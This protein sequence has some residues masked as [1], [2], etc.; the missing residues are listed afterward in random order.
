MKS[1]D[2]WIKS[3]TFKKKLILSFSLILGLSFALGAALLRTVFVLKSRSEDYERLRASYDVLT[4]CRQTFN[5][6]RRAADGVLIGVSGDRQ[7]YDVYAYEM[8][9][10]L[11]QFQML[12]GTMME[13]ENERNLEIVLKTFSARMKPVLDLAE[14]GR[15]SE[16][17]AL[18]DQTVL[19]I[20][21]GIARRIDMISS[22]SKQQADQAWGEAKLLAGKTLVSSG[23]LFLSILLAGA[24]L[25]VGLYRSIAHPLAQ[26]TKGT[27][28][29]S[30][31]L[32]DLKMNIT[33][34][35][36]IAS[37]ASAFET[38]TASLY[39]LQVRLTQMDRMSAMGTLAGGVAHEINNP[40]TGVLGQAQFL[41][42]KLSAT[43][44]LRSNVEKIERGA[45]RCRKI[46]RHLLDFSRPSDYLFQAFDVKPVIQQ[47]LGLCETE[48]ALKSI[49][50]RF[51]SAQPLPKVWASENHL[52]QVFLN[53]LM[54]A[55]Q[56]MPSGGILTIG[57]RLVRP[58]GFLSALPWKEGIDFD[59]DHV[60]VTFEDT[61]EG[62]A[63]ETL[64]RLFDPFFT[65]KEPGKGTG[66]GLSISY[67]IMKVHH[68]EISAESEGPGKG[69]RF[70]VKVPI[71]QDETKVE[72]FASPLSALEKKLTDFED[73]F[74][75]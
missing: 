50:I 12:S 40:L 8:D 58:K 37:L 72:S 28:K 65:T 7:R 18:M 17:I 25:S 27:Q 29:V 47:A 69:A 61:G 48:M 3:L 70:T 45:Q 15:R 21:D 46:V 74:K 10:S 39:A 11:E 62:I 33:D 52:E 66:L 54:N 1:L 38:M 75:S 63:P 4:N 13:K 64:P 51:D 30:E 44:P 71:A 73:R 34:P 68:G 49:Q 24:G 19:P 23:I 53:I 9:R 14:E 56:A 16:A 60:S 67:N 2:R 35:P 59:R 32:W 5:K 42:D 57:L 31:G 22:A 6:M 36:E 41:M 55:V 20:L 26:L 43:D